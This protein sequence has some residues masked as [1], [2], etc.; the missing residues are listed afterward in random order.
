MESHNHGEEIDAACEDQ[1]AYSAHPEYDPEG[2]YDASYNAMF[3]STEYYYSDDHP[4][5][6]DDEETYAS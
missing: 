1:V 5:E 2:N 4:I 6:D 3:A